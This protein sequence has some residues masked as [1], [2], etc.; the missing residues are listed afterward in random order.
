MSGSVSASRWRL[1]C[2]GVFL[3][4]PHHLEGRPLPDITDVAF[5]PSR[6]GGSADTLAHRQSSIRPSFSARQLFRQKVRS[7]SVQTTSLPALSG[8]VERHEVTYPLQCGSECADKEAAAYRIIVCHGAL[9][10]AQITDA[11]TT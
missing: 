3:F 9:A 1:P 7:S 10:S 6:L 11:L 4:N 2:S 5:S 8:E